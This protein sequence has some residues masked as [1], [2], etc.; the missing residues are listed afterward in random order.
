MRKSRFSACQAMAILKQNEGA[1]AA[2]NLCRDPSL[3][4]GTALPL[5]VA[6]R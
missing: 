5:V 2:A 1:R 3:R 6:A 4:K